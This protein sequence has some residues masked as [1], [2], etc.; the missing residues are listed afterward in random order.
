MTRTIRIDSG[1]ARS[2]N[3]VAPAPLDAGQIADEVTTWAKVVAARGLK[4]Q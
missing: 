3:R 1:P 2:G 4:V